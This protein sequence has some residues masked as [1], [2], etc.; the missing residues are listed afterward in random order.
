LPREGVNPYRIKN[1]N[2]VEA[3]IKEVFGVAK[4][5][6]GFSFANCHDDKVLDRII[7]IYPII[8]VKMMSLRVS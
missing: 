5:R 2:V 7:E 8:M 1:I 3:E 4:G 6:S